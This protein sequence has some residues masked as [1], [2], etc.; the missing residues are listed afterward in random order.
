VQSTDALFDMW[1][2]LS[3]FSFTFLS[4]PSVCAPR[5]LP[6]LYEH[7]PGSKPLATGQ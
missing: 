6:V 3:L 5:S 1:L 4:F 7:P 2:L